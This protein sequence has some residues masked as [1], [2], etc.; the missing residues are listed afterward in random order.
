[1]CNGPFCKTAD[2]LVCRECQHTDSNLLEIEGHTETANN[3][4][5]DGLLFLQQENYKG[6]FFAGCTFLYCTCV[7]TENDMNCHVFDKAMALC[8]FLAFFNLW[9]HL[10][11]RADF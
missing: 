8:H 10:T 3:L 9:N 7:V 6:W 4:F 2:R 5:S 11:E 1:M